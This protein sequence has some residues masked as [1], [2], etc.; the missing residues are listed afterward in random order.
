[1]PTRSELIVDHIADY[2]QFLSS[3]QSFWFMLNTSYDHCCHLANQFRLDP[4]DYKVLLIVAGLASYMQFGI[5][6][7]INPTAWREFLCLRGRGAG[8]CEVLS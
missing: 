1:M 5:T 6:I 2:L 3:A 4:E 8:R 7:K